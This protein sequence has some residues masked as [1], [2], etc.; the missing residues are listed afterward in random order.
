M[1]APNGYH[2]PHDRGESYADDDDRDSDLDLD[3]NELDPQSTSSARKAPSRQPSS[4]RT[5][6]DFGARIPLRNLRLG[7]R[8]RPREEDA[9]DL[10]A[11]VG[12]D[13]DEES[14]K[15]ESAASSGLSTRDDDAP[16]LSH[17][18]GSVRRLSQQDLGDYRKRRKG[19]WQ[20]IPFANPSPSI[21]LPATGEEEAED[22]HDPSA[23]RL[24]SVG[25]KQPTRFPPNGVSNAKYTPWSFLPRTLFNEFKFFFNM[26][27]L[28]V[29][30]SQ[31]FPALR[32]GYLSTYIAPLAFVLMITLGKEAYD[33]VYRRKRDN[34]ANSEAYRCLRFDV[35][36][37]PS[38]SRSSGLLK[39]KIKSVSEKKKGKRRRVST[40]DDTDRVQQ[41]EDEEYR[42]QDTEAPSSTVREMVK[43]ARDLKVGDV[44]VLGK[45]QRV[46]ADVVILKSFAIEAATQADD[47]N[48][49]APESD[50]RLLDM[51]DSAS[52]PDQSLQDEAN[53]G[54][55]LDNL[56]TSSDPSGGGEAF[57]RTDQLDGETDWKLRLA[58]PL[59]QTLRTSEYVRLRITA[60]KPDK[61]VNDFVGTIE[62]DP[63]HRGGY[64]PPVDN[65]HSPETTKAKSS[66]LT[67]DNTAWA[68]TVLASSTTVYAVVVYTGSQTRA[69]LST[70]PSRSKT[71]LLENEINSLTKI[72]CVLTAALSLIL[73]ALQVEL[74]EHHKYKQWYVAAMRFLI[75][76]ST[77]V[78]I[79]LRV[80]LD[81][82][83]SVYAWFI[84]RDPGIPG[85]I[86]RTSTIPE[87]LGR[88]EYLLSDKTGTLTR[89]EMELKKVHV[90]TVS[91]GGDAMEEVSSYV[92][93]AFASTEDGGEDSLFTPS[94]GLSSLS[95]TT[96]TRREMGLRVR[97]LVL[98]LALC[99]N[100]TPTTEE[101]ADGQTKISYQASSPDEI[102]IVQWTE[103]GGLRLTHRDRRRITLQFTGN[104]KTVVRVEILNVFPFTS[105]SKRM[106]IIV[107]FVRNS[108][109]TKDESGEIIFFQKGADTVMT[110]IVAANDW[111]DEETGNMAREGL[112]TLVV[113]RKTLSAQQYAAFSTA[114]TEASLSL[115]GRD[116]AM[117]GVVKQHLERDL[118]LLGVTGVED[119]LQPHVKPS[120]ELL[121]NAGIK[122]WMLTGDKVET[123]RC[124]A[125]SSKLVSRGQHIHTIAGL[126]RRDAAIDALGMLNNHP[127][128]A[129]LI[130]GQSLALYLQYHREAF[131]TQA[132]R[133]PAVIAC[134]CSPTQKADV[135]LLI[136]A[137]TK[138]RVACIGDGGNDVSMIQAA[139]VGVGI[140]GKEGR[141]A[142]L[143]ADFS[144]TQF[145]HL[146]KLLVWHGRNS[147]RRSAK[148]AQFVM[149]RGL[150]ISV[151]QA[152]F[153]IAAKF[154]PDALY[155]DWLLVGYATIYTMMPVF[156]LTLDRDVDEGLANLYPELYKELTT[157]KSLS[158]RTFFIWVAIS[159]YQGLIIQGG[160]E[161]LVPNASSDISTMGFKRMVSVSYSVLIFNELVMVAAEITTWHPIMIFSILGTAAMYFGSIPFLGDYYDLSFVASVGFWWRFAGIAAASLGPV[162]AGKIIRRRVKPPS[163][164]KVQGV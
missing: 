5:S 2:K 34:E 70:S 159:I 82:G 126:K 139:D 118:E 117:T 131:I 124:V 36:S 62:V 157:G 30:L 27:F 112:R 68:N 91:Y 67:I 148:L 39:R 98:A 81:M 44:I 127:N 12:G 20:Y 25:Q 106:G 24:I 53:K 94:A 79:S 9:D 23:T 97:D 63:R 73:V 42:T 1:T 46:P 99:H 122:I 55:P 137:F 164:R 71:G 66:P 77:I 72:L 101:D 54:Q 84:H 7:G 75:L 150:I 19:L 145:A 120:L 35:G 155:R 152:I 121:R 40:D 3:L 86:V 143:A 51:G 43:P 153:S 88:I 32:I 119:K 26:Y 125:V 57:I 160:S 156:S 37:D 6:Y 162:Y 15:R 89:N 60:G 136:R 31:M 65:E 135:A 92:K 52:S 28:L 114:Y 56:T 13:D 115:S 4:R 133:L 59:A 85:T 109:L 41:A 49:H 130:D 142:S 110:S 29:A 58:T 104:G 90:G 8:R 38:A 64:D 33:D 61:K 22:E 151:C 103:S 96:R 102:A 132:V 144:I 87:D 147:Y 141:Q 161:L 140:V 100:V 18:N 154:E 105:D 116:A 11:L 163:Y 45:D 146:T 47:G 128:A 14:R 10:Q 21:A 74:S 107:R 76:F 93:Q 80:N 95:G 158:Y 78:P 113:G 111:L 17:A 16:L 48:E 69:A 134:R 123:A 149:H 129:L 108:H 138:K 83:K 50:D